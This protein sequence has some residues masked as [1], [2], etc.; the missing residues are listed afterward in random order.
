MSEW[1]STEFMMPDAGV[2]C[3]CYT[4]LGDIIILSHEYDCWSDCHGYDNDKP[5]HWQPLPE[6]PKD[7]TK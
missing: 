1:I 6:P 2:Y 7:A 5:T 4:T 3:L